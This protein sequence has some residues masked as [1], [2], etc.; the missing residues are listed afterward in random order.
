MRTDARVAEPHV[1]EQPSEQRRIAELEASVASMA[2]ALATANETIARLRERYQRA[3]EKLALAERRI[4]AGKAERK[5]DTNDAQLAFDGAFAEL[6]ALE[7]ELAAVTGAAGDPPPPS[8]PPSEGGGDAPAKKPDGRTTPSTTPTGRRDLSKSSLPVEEYEVLDPALEGK[9]KRIGFEEVQR[10]G[11]RRGGKVRVCLRIAVYKLF[12]DD[13]SIP[14]TTVGACAFGMATVCAAERDAFGAECDV[15]TAVVIALTTMGC[16]ASRTARAGTSGHTAFRMVTAAKPKEMLKR[17]LLAPSMI[18]HLL[19]QKYVMGVP[20]HRL[21]QKLAFEEFPVDRGTMCRYAEHIGA[22]LGAIVEAARVHFIATA[23]CLS[24]DATG[25]SIQP[26]P[27]ADGSRQP[28]RK[29]HF[30]VTLADRDHVFFDYQPKHNS[31]A[32]WTMFK[33]YSGYIQAD[34]HV[35]YD[36]LFRGTPPEGAEETEDEAKKRGPPPKE[37]ACWSHSRRKFWEAAVCRHRVGIEGLRRINDIFAAD[38]LLADL[39]PAQRKARRDADV[40]PLIDEFFAWARPEKLKLTGRGL[41]ATAIGYALNHEEAFRRFL[42][43]GRLRLENNRAENALRSIA[44]ARKAWLFFGSDDHASAAA[45]L[46]S[47]VA[48]CKL[49]GL[50]AEAYLADV[51]RVM[52]YWPP[53]RYVELAPK[54]WT[55]TRARLDPGELKRPLGH[56]TPP[57][58]LT[59]EEQTTTG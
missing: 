14:S 21:E 54:F 48:S 26:T 13:A 19:V 51:I 41:V 38:A 27:L 18:A 15:G 58:P 6:K 45:N 10:L 50:D 39:A 23:F 12:V 47:L 17:G 22:T 5:V 35:I 28:C 16:E 36:A 1:E 57:P 52:P 30:F 2:R 53:Q 46:F 31:L 44:T 40:R 37:C 33:G 24:T 25:A 4:I 43:D 3:L 55:S 59:A 11:F 49:H 7:K 42:E 20:F 56:V 34:A 29:G 32:V 9:A 8:P